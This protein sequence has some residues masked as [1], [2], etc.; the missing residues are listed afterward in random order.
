MA[1]AA[2]KVIVTVEEIVSEDEIRA[3]KTATKLFRKLGVDPRNYAGMRV[4][5]RGWVQSFHGPE[6]QIYAPEA[7]EVLGPA[8]VPVPVP[9]DARKPD[10]SRPDTRRPG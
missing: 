6:I 1:M 8:V 3:E 7:V 9:P 10:K 5:V 2:S 4:R